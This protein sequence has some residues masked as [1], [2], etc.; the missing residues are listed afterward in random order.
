MKEKKI[1][2]EDV[3]SQ[4]ESI[5]SMK[6]IYEKKVFCIKINVYCELLI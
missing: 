5:I 4:N 3:N 6:N 2:E 1:A